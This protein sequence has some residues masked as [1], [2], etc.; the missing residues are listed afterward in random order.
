MAPRVY[1]SRNCFSVN[2]FRISEYPTKSILLSVLLRDRM[3]KIVFKIFRHYALRRK[4]L[5]AYGLH[6][7]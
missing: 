4:I 5:T 7:K 3:S 1:V 2:D 6:G